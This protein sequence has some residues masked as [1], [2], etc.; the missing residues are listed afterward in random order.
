M[1][2]VVSFAVVGSVAVL[3]GTW[4]TVESRAQP[5]EKPSIVGA[6]T[7]NTELSDVIRGA[8]GERGEGHGRGAGGRG[9]RGGH[10]GGGGG[11]FGGGFGRG[12]GGGGGRA[13]PNPEET[14]RLREALR[15]IMQPGDHLTIT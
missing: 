14:E 12:G 9:G 13:M 4:L 10:G 3:L 7:R 15:T 8:D 11:G 1:R 2:P 6:W 5:L